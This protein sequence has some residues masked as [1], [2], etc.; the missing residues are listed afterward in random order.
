MSWYGF[1]R[2]VVSVTFPLFLPTEVVGNE[3]I[4]VDGP[5]IIC[6]NHQS[7]LD[8]LLLAWVVRKDIRFMAKKELFD[9]KLL[10]WLMRR[11]QAIPVDRGANDLNAI[12]AS[13]TVLKNNEYLGIFPEGH[14]YTDGQLHEFQNGVSLLVTRSKAKVVP[15]M[16]HG[17]YRIF[18][19]V[20]VVIGEPFEYSLT[21]GLNGSEQ[22]NTCTRLIY[23]RISNCK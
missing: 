7:F 4:P 1:A 2:F 11:L 18:R 16:I 21:P 12:R 8:P 19:K 13:M 23:E 5:C 6:S 15:I 3:N 10:G 14:R 20:R 22:L 17:N 9:S